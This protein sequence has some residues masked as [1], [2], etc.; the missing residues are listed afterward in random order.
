MG[1][2]THR[3]H[4]SQRQGLRSW[5]ATAKAA[6]APSKT[7]PSLSIQRM[8]DWCPAYGVP[9]N[10]RSAVLEVSEANWMLGADSLDKTHSTARLQST[11]LPS[12]NRM[13][14][15]VEDRSRIRRA[16][17]PSEW[18][19]PVP[20]FARLEKCQSGRMGLT[21]NQVC[22]HGYRGFESLLLRRDPDCLVRVFSWPFE[23]VCPKLLFL[24][25]PSGL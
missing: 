11:H 14:A 2:G 5:V 3:S 15:D 20:I 13:G 1:F 7:R 24:P 10:R 16:R 9:A 4:V 17:S 21:R 22:P 6:S 12:K 19:A 23:K 25:T 8:E 18:M